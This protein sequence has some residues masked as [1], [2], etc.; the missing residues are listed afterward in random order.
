M[1]PADNRRTT[2][3]K[4]N[5]I[6]GDSDEHNKEAMDISRLLGIAM[7]CIG[8][9]MD[10]FCRCTPLEFNEA[11]EA[12]QEMQQAQERGAWERMRMQCLCSL[13]PYSK[14]KLRAEDIM[15]FPWESEERK[16]KGEESSCAHGRE[17]LSHEELMA[18]YRKA[19]ERFGLT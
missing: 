2:S 3:R 12:W 1:E 11:Y 16:A 13:Q 9:S 14:D 5:G 6:L 18:R 15:R 19:R 8:M 4:K 10:D 7:G 17:E